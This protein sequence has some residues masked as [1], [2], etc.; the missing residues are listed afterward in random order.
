MKTPSCRTYR[1][2]LVWKTAHNLDTN[3]GWFKE[4]ADIISKRLYTIGFESFNWAFWYGNLD[5]ECLTISEKKIVLDYLGKFCRYN[6][7]D[8]MEA[9]IGDDLPKLTDLVNAVITKHVY[10]TVVTNP[11]SYIEVGELSTAGQSSM[12][13]LAFGRGL[14]ELWQRLSRVDADKARQWRKTTIKL[15]NRVGEYKIDDWRV[16]YWTQESQEALCHRLASGMLEGCQALRLLLREITDPAEMERRHQN[17]VEVY[18]KAI[19]AV[20]IMGTL[21][22]DFE[23]HLDARRCGPYLHCE[24][25]RLKKKGCPERDLPADDESCPEPVLIIKPLVVTCRPIDK[26]EAFLQEG[27]REDCRDS[28]R[29]KVGDNLEQLVEEA[30]PKMEVGDTWFTASSV[31]PR[32]FYA[33]DKPQPC[34][35]QSRFSCGGLCD[36]PKGEDK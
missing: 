15:L 8:A 31:H 33:K 10:E 30:Y 7:W 6:D 25:K 32:I 16:A 27:N 35:C 28:L 18:R 24:K 34:C 17:L 13:P 29:D 20:V 26:E 19:D 12:D 9:S 3:A 14:Y 22:S 21:N 23:F 36:L 5:K 11:F 1:E 4:N 2:S